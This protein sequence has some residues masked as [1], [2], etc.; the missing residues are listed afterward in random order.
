MSD[1]VSNV[2]IE[3]V[4]S[5]IRRLVSEDSRAKPAPRPAPPER[6][7]LTPALRVPDPEDQAQQT[8]ETG[9]DAPLVLEGAR[10]STVAADPED[11]ALLQMPEQA[12]EDQAEL[13]GPVDDAETGEIQAS[14]WA[15]EPQDT[16]VA[17][18][19]VDTAEDGEAEVAEEATDTFA[20]AETAVETAV[21]EHHNETSEQPNTDEI[22]TDK[23]LQALASM[24]GQSEQPA[25]EMEL[26]LDAEDD[27]SSATEELESLLSEAE[28]ETAAPETETALFEGDLGTADN[29]SPQITTSD[30]LSK[31]VEEEVSRALGEDSGISEV[32]K[33]DAPETPVAEDAVAE[34]RDDQERADE[35]G[36][37]VSE[38]L[39][40]QTGDEVSQDAEPHKAPEAPEA[41]T[42]R[43]VRPSHLTLV[44]AAVSDS[45]E[46]DEE[47]GP[48]AF[49]ATPVSE[50]AT[51]D[52]SLTEV[53]EDEPADLLD[54]VQ[55][56]VDTAEETVEE[57]EASPDMELVS[58]AAEPAEDED[59]TATAAAEVIEEPVNEERV[60]EEAVIEEAEV[61]EEVGPAEPVE[62][63]GA[64]PASLAEKIAALESIVGSSNEEW[65]ADD[66]IAQAAFFQRSATMEWRD[67]DPI[68]EQQPA[69]P[70]AASAAAPAMLD[71]EALR[72]LV[73]DI[74]R[75]E[76]K[77][78]LGERITRN[79]R[80]LV[81]REIHRIIVS[82]ELD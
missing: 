35:L 63:S 45:E 55:V 53:E 41:P 19:A 42:E 77:G 29:E 57:N 44:P 74:I 8:P 18:E 78:V 66:S 52:A 56:L 33:Q 25:S 47:I 17:P 61:L 79:V 46:D 26:P 43:A 3:D 2:E 24:T 28:P 39:D 32:W 51:Q 82:Q 62:E 60:I 76:L 81:R 4:L 37:D 80:K 15:E 38:L 20:E 73:S 54:E 40:G 14:D 31:L 10:H 16:L 23:V 65:E 49:F 9:A 50:D 12:V 27:G 30:I 72:E 21:V 34:S 13:A 11:R 75:E 67:H 59:H 5:S 36:F 6:L 48:E 1:P 7:V 68:A 69:S 70:A 64:E 58:D 71:E 22:D